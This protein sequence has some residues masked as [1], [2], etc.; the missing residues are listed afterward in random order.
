MSLVR[1]DEWT[2]MGWD[3]FE[4]MC[5]EYL[6]LR[7]PNTEISRTP[8]IHNGGKDIVLLVS[9]PPLD[10]EIWVECKKHKR[11]IGLEALGKNVVLIVIRNIQMLIVMSA[12]PVTEGA[13]I[14]LA[15]FA[16]KG[17]FR[18]KF[19]DGENLGRELSNYPQILKKYLPDLS[20]QT[21]DLHSEDEVRVVC[22]VSEFEDDI[23]AGNGVGELTLK[24]D[25]SFY[26]H[27]FLKNMSRDKIRD[28]GV[29]F[30]DF[31]EGL[32]IS[33]Q[34]SNCRFS[35][36]ESMEDRTCTFYCRVLSDKRI[37]QLPVLK[38]GFAMIDGTKR[39]I[40]KNIGYV[41][42]VFLRKSPLIGEKNIDFIGNRIPELIGDVRNGYAKL[43]DI[44]GVSG[45]GKTRLMY[46][47][48]SE[49]K[50]SGF[51]VISFDCRELNDY[52][53]FRRLLSHL[54]GLP[55][56]QGYVK[57]N[58]DA[59]EN[60]FRI[61][62]FDVSYAD[63][64]HNFLVG[65]EIEEDIHFYLTE[66]LKH[67][68]TCR[69]KKTP[70]AILIDNIQE[71]NPN[72]IS[73]V[74][75]LIDFVKDRKS[76]LCLVVS[77]NTEIIP[78]DL[79][80][81][82]QS[83]LTRIDFMRMN[84]RDFVVEFECEEFS[85]RD[86]RLFIINRFPGIHRDDRII[87]LLVEK[88]GRRVL[89]L[90]ILMYFME[91]LGALRMKGF[92]TWYI[93]DLSKLKEVVE[94]I[95]RD[96]A[97][98][99]E[100]RMVL[101]KKVH[102]KGR[103]RGIEKALESLVAFYGKIPKP[104]LQDLGVPTDVIDLLVMKSFIKYDRYTD[105]LVFYHENLYRFFE[106]EYPT[107]AKSTCRQILA[108]LEDT[109]ISEEIE[110]RHKIAFKCSYWLQ[111][112]RETI[113]RGRDALLFYSSMQNHVDAV[114]IGDLL[115]PYLEKTG[116][117]RRDFL[118]YFNISWNYA[119]SLLHYINFQRGLES[120]NKLYS[121]L[122][123]T[124]AGIPEDLVNGFMHNFVNANL[125]NWRYSR[126]MD[127]LEEHK[128]M[129][130]TDDNA[131]FLMY[132]RFAVV[133]TAM[134]DSERAEM[135]IQK[136]LRIARTMKD[137]KCLSIA[138]SDQGYIHLNITYDKVEIAKGF[139]A[140]ISSYRESC[141]RPV[142]RKIEINQQEAII[143]FLENGYTKASRH[144]DQALW[145]CRQNH[146]TLLQLRLLNLKAACQLMEGK[147]EEAERTLQYARSTA[148]IFFNEKSR[149]RILANLGSLYFI[150][151]NL[152]KARD[153]YEISLENL[154][155][156]Q[157]EATSLTKELPLLANLI[158]LYY[159]EGEDGKL[160]GILAGYPHPRL[161]RYLMSLRENSRPHDF[162]GM[163]RLELFY[164][165]GDRGVSLFIT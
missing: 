58:V 115:V 88:A 161:E 38:V 57:Y 16:G 105:S 67:F 98:V 47:S 133:C 56:Y 91:D 76:S 24:R 75:E 73:V 123:C 46:E 1:D 83:F 4:E 92:D 112:R 139:R 59:L 152:R 131:R 64:I 53:L 48:A 125:H 15:R 141:D 149:W 30:G 150:Q 126:A 100:K 54:I 49:M 110:H 107:V 109:E 128:S 116:Y 137:R 85:M 119:E 50:N 158:L 26:I 35:S 70:L 69:S 7:Y 77:T 129:G 142:F 28:I 135:Y 11:P 106:R 60:I 37:V 87:N 33:G 34:D 61:Y 117:D 122:R 8:R 95:P 89:D 104:C 124:D 17:N 22:H 31:D 78:P 25:D 41:D 121:D 45:V 5:Y 2:G 160:K 108:W 18:I 99:V 79:Y 14:Q 136:A 32:M 130:I 84:H 140:A 165:A 127:L 90:E 164:V 71:L 146:Y 111:D 156:Q 151:G 163:E 51:Q 36:I 153:Y 82:I 42:R 21:R 3:D 96:S 10:S 39:E 134:G 80:D 9:S 138:Y 97:R 154:S 66:T 81:N 12:S 43:I 155:R 162:D 72:A 86:A 19:L 44:R 114:E 102:G 113:S 144:I 147:H 52:R 62:G 132:D 13:K 157:P 145:I 40:E 101:L 143:D 63:R 93:P 23:P 118:D 27:V 103:W 55:L 148:E 68:L 120:Y 20:L 65:T 74:E 6:C 159:L 94:T 29:H